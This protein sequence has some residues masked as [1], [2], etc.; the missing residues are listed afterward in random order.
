MLNKV[1]TSGMSRITSWEDLKKG[2]NNQTEK[3]E[4]AEKK[5][6]LKIDKF[7][8]PEAPKA[9][10][11]SSAAQN[12]LEDLRKKFGNVDFMVANFS[13]D[14]EAQRYLRQGKGEFNCVITPSLLEKMAE[15]EE[16]RAKYED[17]I[18]YAIGGIV[19]MK[20]AITEENAEMV[21]S[22]GISV[23]SEG[24]IDYYVLL[25]DGLP[26][27]INEGSR[28]VKANSIEELMKRLD[29]IAEEKRK[30]KR[31]DEAREKQ[32]ED[33]KLPEKEV[34]VDIEA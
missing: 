29:E 25:R 12:L 28:I 15:C 17:K 2:K 16:L 27:N 18:E 24:G 9:P 30:Q 21:K 13:S 34:V 31:I 20:E 14:R 10:A 3:K 7:E 5:S 22:Y 19:E 6:D 8:R 4:Q 11:L 23:N 32:K 1:N 26:K 33:T